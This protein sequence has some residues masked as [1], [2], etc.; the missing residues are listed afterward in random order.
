MSHLKP[1]IALLAIPEVAASTLYGMN[2]VFASAGR[3]WAALVEGK[4]GE[5]VLDP[6][7]VSFRGPGPMTLTNGV[8]I[9]PDE[10]D[11]V[12]PDV[13]CVPEV[14][15]APGAVLTD[16]HRDEIAWLRRCYEGGAIVA[17]ACSGALLLAETGLLN[18][19][20][21]TTH[22]A[23]CDALSC[24]PGVQVHPNRALVV[25]GEGGRL[26]MAGGGTSW[27]D[28]ALYLVARLVSVDEAMHIAKLFLIDWHDVGQLPYAALARG[29]QVDDAGIAHCQN[30]IAEHY[31]RSSPVATMIQLSGMTERTFN[32]RFK[33][34]TGMSPIDYVHT[35]RIEEAKQL[36]ESDDQPVEAIAQDV[37]YEDAAF[38]GRLFRRKVG[39]TPLQYRKRFRGLRRALEA[40]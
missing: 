4:K 32:R 19:S 22:W 39:I 12:V 31:E 27:E 26:I 17:T 30:W 40:T 35:L 1:R 13:V 11:G 8:R 3:D 7:V 33:L 34:A 25:G 21:A 29:S 18:G 20:E 15:V 23:Y 2:D 36:L 14:A 16:S 24:Y 28:L 6:R 38:F 10:D 37:G 9:V 5:S